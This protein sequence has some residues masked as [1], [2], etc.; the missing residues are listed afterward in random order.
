MF[1]SRM[2][3]DSLLAPP[4]SASSARFALARAS[5]AERETIFRLRHE[6]YARELGQ[7]SVNDTGRLHDALDTYN[8][9]LVARLDG[10]VAGFIS[11]TPPGRGAFSI[12]KY[13]ARDALPFPVDGQLYEVRLLTV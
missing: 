2:K 13:F 12:D 9:N 3:T 7:H 4:R 11:I 1:S 5:D 6:V 10:A 8:V